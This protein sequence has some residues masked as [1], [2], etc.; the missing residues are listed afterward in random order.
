[1]RKLLIAAL[2]A[3]SCAS[4]ALADSKTHTQPKVTAELTL[5]RVSLDKAQ[6]MWR[7]SDGKLHQVTIKSYAHP[8]QDDA[9]KREQT[10]FLAD[11]PFGKL[12]H[13]DLL[14]TQMEGDLR[15]TLTDLAPGYGDTLTDG[16]I[17]LGGIGYIAAGGKM[18]LNLENVG[19]GK[20]KFNLKGGRG[21][22]ASLTYKVLSEND[23][24]VG[25]YAGHD[26][27]HGTTVRLGF[28]MKFK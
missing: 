19:L 2:V 13:P 7:T 26:G 8:S 11:G 18:P 3:V 24:V 6:L 23:G 5:R 20:T 15:K 4:P 22:E 16:I 10:K 25:L 17:G 28:S 1:M 14:V 21:P 12:K 9:F 27:D